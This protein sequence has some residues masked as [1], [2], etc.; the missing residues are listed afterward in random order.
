MAED[1]KNRRV[2]DY[3]RR[4]SEQEVKLTNPTEFFNRLNQPTESKAY[5][6]FENLKKTTEEML[7]TTGSHRILEFGPEGKWRY[8]L[9]KSTAELRESLKLAEKN[10]DYF[11]RE[12]NEM[13]RRFLGEDSFG[14]DDAG[15]TIGGMR[16]PTRSEYT[17][18]IGSPFYK[19]LY[20]QD[21]W[22]MHSKCF[23]FSNYSGIGRMIVDLTRNFVMGKG[24]TVQ[25]KDQRAETAWKR[26]EELSSIQEEARNW[27]DDLTKFGEVMIRKIPTRDGLIHRSID[28]ST[29]WEIVT[30]PENIRDVKYYHQQYN[31][32]YQLFGTNDAPTSKYV[33]NQIPAALM[34][35]STVNITSYEK[36]GRSDLLAALVYLKYYE[37]FM[38]A[39]LIRTKNE[40]AFIWDV[41]IK[42]GDED[43]RAYINS[44][45]SI[46]DVPPG[47]ENV[48]NEAVERKPLSPQFGQSTRDSDVAQNIL[49]YV[50]MA[51]SI[52]V[53]YFGTFGTGGYTKAGAL[54]ATEP[55]AKKMIERQMKMEFVITRIVKDVLKANGLDPNQEF[56]VTFP[57]ILEEDRSTKMKDLILAHD[58]KVISHATLSK[59]L[60]KELKISKYNYET[61]KKELNAEALGM[62]GDNKD[63]ADGDLT[64][65]DK[66]SDTD[67][68]RAFDR[69]TVKKQGKTY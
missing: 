57:E 14:Y 6:F 10:R 28:P 47:S 37:D 22:E 51:T 23:W 12:N 36:R 17:P 21:Y 29:V 9:I 55:V 54:V 43:V 65:G 4:S 42:G 20:L 2:L 3:V 32:Q 60:A 38:T 24:F 63:D 56:E 59:M 34:L 44:A 50:A 40:A 35:H 16:N 45:D 18:L 1:V 5:A 8:K 11:L 41:T 26:Y 25:F 30:D 49:S 52:P 61:E 13:V 53:N 15:N 68:A 31:T 66:D 64:Q 33:I 27:C 39:S 69:D 19:Q 48:H 67:G 46:A 7:D 58:A 62:W